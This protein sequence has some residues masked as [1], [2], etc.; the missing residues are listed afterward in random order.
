LHATPDTGR[1]VSKSEEGYISKTVTVWRYLRYMYLKESLDNIELLKIKNNETKPLCLAEE[2]RV[3]IFINALLDEDNCQIVFR[4]EN[5]KS[6]YKNSGVQNFNIPNED[7]KF[8][9]HGKSIF[10]I[11]TKAKSYLYSFDEI[12]FPIDLNSIE[13]NV[14]KKIFQELNLLLSSKPQDFEK[15]FRDFFVNKT[16][17]DFTH[18]ISKL[19]DDEKKNIKHYYLWFLHVMGESKYKKYSNYLSTTKNYVTASIFAKKELVYCGWIPRPI[20][21]RSIY[22]GTLIQLSTK[23][24]KLKLPIYT[25]EPYPSE[26][27]I[28]LIGGFFPH[29]IL[30][31]YHLP[32]R[33]L[34]VNTNL[35]ENAHFN[36][37][38]MG[39]SEFIIENG[40][41]FDQSNF[42]E[43]EHF[44]NSEY[45]RHVIQKSGEGFTDN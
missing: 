41:S 39:N 30:G 1:Y 34:L 37:I 29:Y 23:L 20:K 24:Q 16:E 38:D 4:G 15:E 36:L 7:E 5:I 45:K 17:N 22:L 28:S 43:N 19:K 12:N 18:I 10:Y 9:T 26:Q 44:K 8:C 21:E 31:I 2:K 27:E 6:A 3:R 42:S 25:S 13:D 14:F 33:K 35:L 11:G 40:I 32:K